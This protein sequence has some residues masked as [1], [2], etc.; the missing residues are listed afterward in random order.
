MNDDDPLAYLQQR[1]YRWGDLQPILYDRKRTDLF[2]EPYLVTLYQRTRASGRSKLGS[3]PNLFC[4]M[5]DLSCEAIVTFLSQRPVIVMGEWRK[6][7]AGMAGMAGLAG[8]GELPTYFHPLGYVLLA[9][10]ILSATGERNAAFAGYCFFQEAW[11]TPQQR[12]LTY[13]TLAFLFQEYRLVSLLAQ[14]YDDNKLT[15]RWMRQFGLRDVATLPNAMIRN[16]G[17]LEEGEGELTSSVVSVLDRAD[18]EERLRE[19]MARLRL[20]DR[21]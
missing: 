17:G 21:P 1:A 14:R 12:V 20:E 10:L 2:P 8:K 4:G 15:A 6:R 5:T 13:L 9:P 16:H 7:L 11:R 18:F 3:L 19:L